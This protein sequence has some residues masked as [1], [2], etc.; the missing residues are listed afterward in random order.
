[1]KPCNSV[2]LLIAVTTLF[3]GSTLA[4]AQDP[5]DFQSKTTGS[6]WKSASSWQVYN[7]TIFVDSTIVPGDT[8]HTIT[9]VNGSTISLD[10][11][12]LKLKNLT[13]ELGGTL[14][15][16]GQTATFFGNKGS[17][18][19]AG[20]LNIAG[21]SNVSLAPYVTIN[22]SSGT[23]TVA[24]GS[25]FSGS[26]ND[27]LMTSGTSNISTNG[28][29]FTVPILVVSG[30]TTATTSGSTGDLHGFVYVDT[31]GSATATLAIASGK[32]IT[33]HHDI[34]VRPFGTI[35]GPGSIIYSGES[36]GFGFVNNGTVTADVK[37]L[38]SGSGS[39]RFVAQSVNSWQNVEI[40]DSNG[41][42][43]NPVF[44]GAN[45]GINGTLTLT[46]GTLTATLNNISLANNATIVRSGG[47]L[48]KAPTFGTNVNVTYSGSTADTTSFEL[49]TS[50]S[51]LNNLTMNQSAGLTLGST[52]MVNG[53]LTFTQGIIK[54]VNDTLKIGSAGSV[55]RASGHIQGYLQKHVGTGSPSLTFEIGDSVNYTPIDI[56]FGNVTN[57]GNLTANVTAG[58]H[59]DVL[60]SGLSRTKD[61]NRFWTVGNNRTSFDNYS[62]TPHFVTT[63]IDAGANTS[64]FVV[65]KKDG[66][67]WS[68]TTTGTRSSTT[69]QATGMTTFSDFAV[70]E[71]NSAP[72]A[73]A[74]SITGT[75]SVGQLLTGHYTYSDADSDSQGTSTFRWLRDG[76][77]IG[78]ATST[79]YTL[80]TADQ[81]KSITFEA[82]PVAQT[83]VLTGI[84]VQSAGLGPIVGSAFADS[85]T[86]SASPGTIVANGSSTSV[87]TVQLRDST[88]NNLLAS[89]GT[90]V[91]T[92]TIGSLGPVIDNN[93]GTYTDTLTSGTITGPDT[94][95]GTLNSKSIGRSAVVTFTAGAA[96]QVLVET[97]ANGSGSVLG[98]QNVMAGLSV[99]GYAIT[100]DAHDNFVANVAA[101]SWTLTNVVGGVV[102]GD[103]VPAGDSKSAI[104]TGHLSGS[105]RINVSSG[106]LVATSSGVLTVIPGTVSLSHSTV[107]VARSSISAGDTTLVTLIAKDSLGN[108]ET[109]GGLAVTFV[110]GTGT[111]KGAFAATVDSGNGKYVAIFTG[112]TSGTAS[113]IIGRIA[114]DSVTTALPT[115]T[116]SPAPASLS[117][118]TVTL[119]RTSITAG[120]TTLV[121]LMVRDSL[122]NQQTSGGL[123]VTFV[124]GS[125]G[126]RGTFGS[127]VDNGNGKYISVF[128]GDTSGTATTVI[129]RIA[130]NALTTTLPTINVVP[131]P[132]SLSHSLVSVGRPSIASGDT[133]LITLIAKDSLGNRETGGGLTV[134]FVLGGGTSTGTIITPTADSSNGKYTA[135]FTGLASGTARTVIGKIGPDS[136]KSTLPTVTVLPG[137]PAKYLVTSTDYNPNAGTVVVIT[138]Q[139]MD[140]NNNPVPDTGRIITWGS[141]TGG[142]SFGQAK[143]TTSVSGTG[144]VSFTV[145]GVEGFVDSVKATDNSSITGSSNYITTTAPLAVQLRSFSATANH[146]NASLQWKTVTETNNYGFEIQRRMV[147]VSRNSTP[148]SSTIESWTKIAFVPGSGTSTVSHQYSYKDLLLNSGTY[149]YRLKQVDAS[150]KYNYSPATEVVVGLAPKV[151][152][153]EHNY[154]NPF[155]PSTTIEFTVPKDAK[156]TLK[157]FNIIGQE[158][159][160]LF[161][162]VAVA[163]RIQQVKFDASRLPSGVYFS[164]L[165][166]DGKKLV[167]KMMLLK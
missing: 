164:M 33:F 23:V 49:P 121:T 64:N 20:T 162:D 125:G 96:T 71:P 142:G 62:A 103:L 74:V 56:A 119:G 157:V 132:F 143:D 8:L 95:K 158:V 124:L 131:A 1:M 154:P 87:V 81:N 148:D 163:G 146:L 57:A 127:V 136:V 76:G 61:V 101:D 115:I 68:S 40:A 159:V 69:T 32:Q 45:A 137:A 19:I 106:V 152:A 147:S 122:G 58:E 107:S 42:S 130:S 29:N 156:T 9:I 166:Y 43:F 99:T 22:L 93:N 53:G 134:S 7:G 47:K 165:E 123:T 149:S 75:R 59:P 70:G 55:S 41:V 18:N 51:V 26:T 79:T 5:G 73:S 3:L 167:K 54:T 90:V 92:T 150:G 36:G 114:L 98:A 118:S 126:S 35:T 11:T 105:A 141:K 91:L 65:Q 48:S 67:V 39:P 113:T 13:V 38:Q 144:S 110:L 83:G 129:G 25:N 85:S 34:I 111:S 28:P 31:A 140:A 160:T 14:N 109:T 77:A 94:V 117:H 138:A 155:N 63:D 89:G 102:S 50:S 30:T 15:V 16:T 116:I 108:R 133:T 161:D 151:L 135:V 12:G 60:N 27:T 4:V 2:R 88:G 145:S 10:T 78:G 120:D 100:R 72:V 46:Y 52:A 128:T 112:D 17:N 104:F 66:S 153:L 6:S 24:A 97:A 86:I 82:T 37:F 21:S 44:G 139:L 84:P 80:V